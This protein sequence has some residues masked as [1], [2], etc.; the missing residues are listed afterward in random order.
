[1]TEQ[2]KDY[3]RIEDEKFRRISLYCPWN[4]NFCAVTDRLCKKDECAVWH[5]FKSLHE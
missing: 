5:F 3:E 1:M 2:R 4:E